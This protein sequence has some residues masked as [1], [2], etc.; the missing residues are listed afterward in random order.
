MLLY[1]LQVTLPLRSVRTETELQWLKI[2]K[3]NPGKR[4]RPVTSLTGVSNFLLDPLPLLPSKQIPTP[5]RVAPLPSKQ[6][7][8]PTRFAPLRSKQNHTLI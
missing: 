7:P 4:V 1:G 8:P 5:T 3:L 2:G 6:I